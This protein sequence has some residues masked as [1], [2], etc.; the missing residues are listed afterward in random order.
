MLKYVYIKKSENPR[1]KLLLIWTTKLQKKLFVQN[2]KKSLFG[3]GLV[4]IL[5]KTNNLVLV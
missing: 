1:N 2:E 3:Y 4:F 5:E